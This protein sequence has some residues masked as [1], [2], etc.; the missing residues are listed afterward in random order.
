MEVHI[1][2]TPHKLLNPNKTVSQKDR[3]QLDWPLPTKS[4][5][6]IKFALRRQLQET[7]ILSAINGR[8][9]APLRGPVILRFT[10]AYEKGRQIPDWDNCCATLKGVIDGLVQAGYMADD[11]QVRGIFIDRIMDPAKQGYIEVRLEA[12]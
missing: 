9:K 2:A 10:V 7:T 6:V 12:A 3:Q 4:A 8:P 11:D 1:P 5:S